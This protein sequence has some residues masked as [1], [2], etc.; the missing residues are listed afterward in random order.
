MKLTIYDNLGREV[1]QLVNGF[2][3]AG[4]YTVQFNAED[5]PSG[6]YIY[7]IETSIGVLSKKMLLMK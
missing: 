5:L 4:T 6:M 1:K 3:N 7:R 2:K